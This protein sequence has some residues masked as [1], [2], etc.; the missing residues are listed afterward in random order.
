MRHTTAVFEFRISH[1]G[2]ARSLRRVDATLLGL[3]DRFPK[4][5]DLLTVHRV[6]EL[7]RCRLLGALSLSFRVVLAR[8]R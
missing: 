7:F 2:A 6:L 3:T 4:R 5:P 1:R 8:Q